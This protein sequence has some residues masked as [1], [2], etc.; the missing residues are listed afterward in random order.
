[1]T[2]GIVRTAAVAKIFFLTFLAV[3][4]A[5][6]A[7][8]HAQ[9][10]AP[11]GD[12]THN[13]SINPFLVLFGYF[14]GEYEQR[15]SPTLAFA[16]A[17]SYVNFDDNRYTNVD[18]KVR[19]Y[20]NEKALQGFGLAGSVGY[21]QLREKIFDYSNCLNDPFDC[22]IDAGKSKTYSS[23]SVA[24]ELTYQWL[25]GTRKATS[26]TVGG[27]AKRFLISRSRFGDNELIIPTGRM[28]VGYAW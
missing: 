16:L 17:G 23:P 2:T 19:L 12:P 18:A 8:A 9:V 21:T 3:A 14:S 5:P 25:L 1:M 13:I 7:I 26:I 15:R 4:L 28:S 6:P 22:G 27:G 24:I 11:V 10:V 20:P